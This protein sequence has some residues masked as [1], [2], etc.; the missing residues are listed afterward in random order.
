MTKSD[1]DHQ[2][3]QEAISQ[4]LSSIRSRI[5]N[6]RMYSFMDD[7]TE[8][9]LNFISEKC[10]HFESKNK[11]GKT[12]EHDYKILE[13]LQKEVVAIGFAINSD[14]SSNEQI[15]SLLTLCETLE[16]SPKHHQVSKGTLEFDLA[17]FVSTNTRQ[18]LETE[19]SRIL[20]EDKDPDLKEYLSTLFVMTGP[21]SN[22]SREIYAES[23]ISS[24]QLMNLNKQLLLTI[25][26]SQDPSQEN[27]KTVKQEIKNHKISLSEKFYS[28]TLHK[29]HKIIIAYLNRLAQKPLHKYYNRPLYN[30]KVKSNNPTFTPKD[31]A[32]KLFKKPELHKQINKIT[33]YLDKK[34]SGSK[35]SR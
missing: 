16:K 21:K 3:V 9:L 19:I 22:L 27:I 35:K 32:V 2:W 20:Q 14:I 4:K 18:L 24:F 34:K 12:T 6:T 25:K 8:R 33:E 28:A 11:Q 17:H 23:R 31:S 13:E 5:D 15:D 7:T 30:L 1:D 26:A 10:N 29:L